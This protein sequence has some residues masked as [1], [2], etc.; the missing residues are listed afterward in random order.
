MKLMTSIDPD[1]TRVQ[2][3]GSHSQISCLIFRQRGVEPF[4]ESGGEGLS[5]K[6]LKII[7]HRSVTPSPPFHGGDN[8]GAASADAPAPNAIRPPS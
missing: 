5:G 6:I 8:R 2:E 4:G 1:G 3:I 7:G